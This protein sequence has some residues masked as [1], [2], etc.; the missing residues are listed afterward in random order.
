MSEPILAPPDPQHVRAD[1]LRALTEDVGTGDISAQLLPNQPRLA[2]LIAREPGVLAGS[3][4][5]SACF[6]ELDSH[7]IVR[8][9]RDEGQAF[10][11][12]DTI[13]TVQADVRALLSGER[14]ALNFL[15]T[16]SATATATAAF[17]AALDGTS[18]RVL[19]TRKT[20]PGLRHAQ[21][22]AVR[23]GGGCNHR[24]G[25]YDAAMIKE[26]HVLAAGSIAAAI[27]A[28]RSGAHGL[29]II[30]EVESLDEL[31]QAL[32]CSPER[33]VLDDFT[34]ADMRSAVERVSG[35]VPLEVSGGIDLSTARAIAETG[36]DFISVGAITKHVRAIDFSLRL[37]PADTLP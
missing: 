19:D 24:I 16:L 12:N 17:V 1:V 13:C 6:A 28:A 36:V 30:V 33:I 25:L 37:I 35:R 32:S 22:Y 27:A 4:W 26:N 11:A 34:L 7:A 10:V 2:Q 8:W 21:K 23:A 9:S 31:T 29:P 20:L 15:Q 5:F 18:T 14:S 3:A